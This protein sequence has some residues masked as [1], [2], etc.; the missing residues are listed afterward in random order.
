MKKQTSPTIVAGLAVAALLFCGTGLAK[1]EPHHDLAHQIEAE[2]VHIE[3]EGLLD[4]FRELTKRIHQ[5]E[6]EMVELKIESEIAQS[7]QERT[8]L[9]SH[10]VRA[11]KTH[12]FM[13]KVREQ[14]RE[15]LHHIAKELTPRDHGEERERRG[16]ENPGLE[17]HLHHL[18]REIEE[19]RET[20]KHDRAEHLERQANEIRAH[21]K[22][23][24]RRGR[25]G[26]GEREHAQAELRA[27]FEQL[28][29]KR[30]EA[31]GELEE[32]MVA[33][34]E[35]EGDGE[36]AQAKRHKLEDRAGE[37]KAHLGELTEQL[38]ELEHAFQ[39]R[40][41]GGER[42]R[43]EREGREEERDEDEVRER[44]E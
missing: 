31:I 13:L 2:L 22:Q 4:K 5:L 11:H 44:E 29:A 28:Q 16:D 20:G 1:A 9:E 33:A 23:Q 21:L 37:V 10:F 18:E 25:E 24:E 42:K 30:R 35:I 8:E 41:R 7:D 12:D 38:E 27:H 26:L 3:V 15:K 39:E 36:E 19:L 14:T 32:L 43:E 40:R 17:E 34:K 6:L